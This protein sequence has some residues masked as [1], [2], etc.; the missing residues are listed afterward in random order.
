M[1]RARG[2]CSSSSSSSA[3]MAAVAAVQTPV[4]FAPA[5]AG[6]GSIPAPAPTSSSTNSFLFSAPS[7]AT[8]DGLYED[9]RAVAQSGEGHAPSH[10]QQQQNATSSSEPSSSSFDLIGD[11]LGEFGIDGPESGSPGSGFAPG[12]YW[13]Q[14]V[15]EESRMARGSDDEGVHDGIDEDDDMG[16]RSEDGRA[17][18]GDLPVG[19]DGNLG[20]ARRWG[21][22]GPVRGDDDVRLIKVDPNPTTTVARFPQNGLP[23][24]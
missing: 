10:A 4:I 16:E 18:S 8:V 23:L 21:A 2:V 6:W 22:I 5:T 12:G 15:K 19:G 7:A 24:P 20:D 9:H 11:E 13:H 1:P 17:Q 3:A 14:M